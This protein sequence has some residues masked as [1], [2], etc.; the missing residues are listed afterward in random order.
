MAHTG[1]RVR[2]A[3]TAVLRDT[4]GLT[5]HGTVTDHAGRPGIAVSAGSDNG[6]TR[7]LLIVDP[8]TGDLLAYERTAMRDPGGLGITTPTVLTYT[9]Y[10]LHTH[11]AAVGRR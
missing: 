9:L 7:D 8:H 4:D 10:L 5:Y 11:T 1:T 2:V 6:A 3:A